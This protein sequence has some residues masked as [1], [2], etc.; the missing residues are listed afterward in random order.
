VA[1]ALS[2]SVPAPSKNF[3]V[4]TLSNLSASS[5]RTVIVCAIRWTPRVKPG[6]AGGFGADENWMKASLDALNVRRPV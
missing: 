1:H 2:S 6:E 3:T 4:A 5:F